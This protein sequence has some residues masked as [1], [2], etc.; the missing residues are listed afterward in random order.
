MLAISGLDAARAQMAVSLGFHIVFAALAIG[1]PAMMIFTEYRAIRTGDAGWMEL[2]RRWAK[3]LGIL[4]AV[5]AVSGTVLSFALGLFWPGLMGRWGS[6]IGL[7]FALEAFAFFVEAIFLG[8]YLYGWDRLS[9]WAHWLCGFP[10]A[11]GGAASAWFVVAANA[12][13]QT[14]Q[15]F[16]LARGAVVEVDPITAMLN[17]ST[18]VMTTHMLIAAYMATGFTVA[19]V[20]AVGMLRGRRDALHRRGLAV[21]LV[22]G[23][24]LAPVQVFVGDLAARLVAEHQPVKL[25]AME[26][27]W[28]TTRRAPL[29]IGGIP[30]EGRE[31]TILALRIPGALSWLAFGDT[32]ALVE[33]LSA[34][35]PDERPN[36]LVVHLAYQVMI[37][38]GVGLSGLGVWALVVWRR[39]R[40]PGRWFLRAVVV[41]GP[42]TFVAL[43]SGWI[44]TEVGRQPWIV[45][46]YMR[47]ADAVTSNPGIVWWLVATIT[48]YVSLGAAC[49]WLLARVA[50]GRREAA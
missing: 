21:G 26:G 44:V 4:V 32:D 24:A 7:P 43:E 40:Q 16:E 34:V 10:V 22:A 12:W 31:E 11:I 46:G 37:S 9:P 29:T 2:T 8:I 23:L 13:M 19:A 42:A 35:P 3:S 20:Y 17:P 28:E 14:P 15:G 41:A 5:G 30:L 25:A 27:L 18:P 48:I 33:G 1:L 47:T 39:R 6:V 50:R 38:V 49:A 45:T 36:T